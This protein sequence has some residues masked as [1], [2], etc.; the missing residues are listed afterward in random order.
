ML[1]AFVIGNKKLKKVCRQ[2]VQKA[3]SILKVNTSENM[4]FSAE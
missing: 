3:D 2:N 4:L 1:V